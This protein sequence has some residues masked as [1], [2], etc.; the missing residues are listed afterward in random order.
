MQVERVSDT[1]FPELL[2]QHRLSRGLTQAELAQPAGPSWRGISHLER[3]L[4]H[5]PRTST[6][7]LLIRGL[8]LTEP[9]AAV[10]LRASQPGRLAAGRLPPRPKP[11]DDAGS[12]RTRAICPRDGR[13]SPAHR[14]PGLDET[15][16]ESGLR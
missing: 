14:R 5:A 15:L 12:V 7:R 10:L 3:G 13:G 2:R 9:E 6:V 11:G 1:P 4:K 8:G 16:A